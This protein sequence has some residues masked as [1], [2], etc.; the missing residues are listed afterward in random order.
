VGLAGSSYRVSPENIS[1]QPQS[2]VQTRIVGLAVA[3][4]QQMEGSE[5][6]DA[7]LLA[8]AQ[9][10]EGSACRNANLAQAELTGQLQDNYRTTTG[11][12]TGQLQ[13]NLC[14]TTL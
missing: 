6:T 2:G 7:H 1:T 5:R 10:I 4:V 9:V 14:F 3:G 12:P 11:Q 13:D 8:E